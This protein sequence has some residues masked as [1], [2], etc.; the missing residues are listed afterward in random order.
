MLYRSFVYTLKSTF[1][2]LPEDTF[3]HDMDKTSGLTSLAYTCCILSPSG[4]FKKKKRMKCDIE[5]L[6]ILCDI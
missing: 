4:W 1:R 2:K 3:L 6:F 5:G